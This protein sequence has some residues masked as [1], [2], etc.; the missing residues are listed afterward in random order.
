MA[1]QFKHHAAADRLMSKVKTAEANLAA[2]VINITEI[3][4]FLALLPQDQ[5]DILAVL[6]MSKID[7]DTKINNLKTV[8]TAINSLSF[9]TPLNFK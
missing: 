9:E 5:A 6:G 1:I 2:Y 8:Y 7:M 3:N 4:K